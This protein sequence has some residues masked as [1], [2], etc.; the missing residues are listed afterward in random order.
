MTRKKRVLLGI[1]G[2]VAAVKGPE[3]S[4]RLLEQGFEVKVLLTMGGSNF[5]SKAEDYNSEAWQAM[6]RKEESAE[7]SIHC[8]SLATQNV[9]VPYHSANSDPLD[10]KN[11]SISKLFYGQHPT[12][13]GRHGVTWA[14]PSFTLTCAIG[15]TF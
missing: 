4:L 3:L 7:V 1:T 2:S 5:W 11:E 13:S 15:P 12:M 10:P 6:K 14:T 8:K 9:V